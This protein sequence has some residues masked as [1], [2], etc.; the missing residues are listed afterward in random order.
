LATG[1]SV[2]AAAL[3]SGLLRRTD[4]ASV[5]TTAEVPPEAAPGMV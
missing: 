5:R 1:L 4:S 2:L 3:V